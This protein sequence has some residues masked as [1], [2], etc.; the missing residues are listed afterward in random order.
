MSERKEKIRLFAHL[1]NAGVQMGGWR[2]PQAHDGDLHDFDYYRRMA[3]AAEAA[4]LDALFFADGPGFRRVEGKDAFSRMDVGK[5]EPITLLSALSVVTQRIG[6]IATAST[7]FNEPYNIARKFASLDHLSKGRAGWNAI[8]STGENEAHNFNLDRHYGHAHRYERAEE[9]VD[10][11]RGLW[12]SWDDDA[13]VIDKASGRYFD[14]DKLHALAHRGDHFSVAGPLNVGRAPQGHPLLVQAG[15]SE[16][17]RRLGA[18][19]ADAIFTIS[20]D[21]ASGQAYYADIKRRAAAFGRDPDHIRIMAE[22]QAVTGRTE[23]EAREKAEFLENLIHPSLALSW[24]QMSLGGVDLSGYDIDGPLPDIP[25]T[26]ANVS[27]R[28]SVVE[29]ARYKNLSIRQIAIRVASTRGGL[30]LI[31]TPEQVA[32]EIQRRFDARVA[33]GFVIG[34]A[35]LPG[36]LL[37]F[38]AD[39]LPIL[40]ER[41]L[42]REEYEGETL[43]ENLGLPRPVSVYETNP[44]RHVEPEIWAAAPLVAGLTTV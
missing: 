37:D 39:V 9:F 22:F 15:G 16:D 33:D 43:R 3:E 7:S 32:D 24:L 17:G 36:N 34:A 26:N 20:S 42:F 38:I 14:P 35:Y 6:L 4:K 11:V 13:F 29:E 19:T 12:D 25:E 41:G 30:R 31:G 10:V 23:Q 44:E 28:N 2:H 8:T 5:V 1:L 27:F 21:I 40:K 18:R